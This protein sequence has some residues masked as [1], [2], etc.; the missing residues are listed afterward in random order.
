[1][2]TQREM[3]LRREKQVAEHELEVARREIEV[4]RQLQQLTVT[5]AVRSVP[6]VQGERRPANRR[7]NIAEMADLLDYYD[8]SGG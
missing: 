2:N 6:S 5:Q 3:A 1:M 7:Q 8:G 4:M